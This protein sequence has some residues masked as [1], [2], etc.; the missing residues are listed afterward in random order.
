MNLYVILRRQ[1]WRGRDHPGRR[2]GDR[3]ARPRAGRRL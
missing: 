3:P 1:G 2:H